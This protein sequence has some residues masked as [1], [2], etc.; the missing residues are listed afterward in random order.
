LRRLA[1]IIGAIALSSAAFAAGIDSHASSC[2][3]LHALIAA[4][5][6]VFIN[7]PDFQDFVVADAS[8]CEGG[9][10]IQLRSVPTTDRPECPVNYCVPPSGSGGD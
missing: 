1:F 8:S 4:H 7:N 9:Y 3:E 10:Y 5:R 6:F 2:A